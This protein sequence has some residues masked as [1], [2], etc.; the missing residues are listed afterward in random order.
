[1]RAA[2]SKIY[3]LDRLTYTPESCRA[4]PQYH[5]HF[6]QQRRVISREKL[7]R[8]LRKQLIAIAVCD[9]LAGNPVV[10]YD[11]VV[12][13]AVCVTFYPPPYGSDPFFIFR[14]E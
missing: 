14:W 9:I 1:M 2:D 7:F 13:N 8:N 5:R 4:P 3:G 12:Q 11:S 6:R 10:P